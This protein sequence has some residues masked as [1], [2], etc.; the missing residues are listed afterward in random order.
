MKTQM[1]RLIL[2]CSMVSTAL[3]VVCPEGT[4]GY[5]TKSNPNCASTLSR[6]YD[7]SYHC[8][9]CYNPPSSYSETY[10][11]SKASS[12]C[13]SCRSSEHVV[14][15]DDSCGIPPA[16][17]ATTTFVL[18]GVGVLLVIIIITIYVR[19]RPSSQETPLPGQAQSSLG[20]SPGFTGQPQQMQ[21]GF[22]PINQ[23]VF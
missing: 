10:S 23:A 13:L 14:L 8:K 19:R 4:S 7:C 21:G 20:P 17:S 12:F 16:I 9:T 1:I 2:T 3:T 15:G 22:Q 11:Y 18:I 5:C 6:C